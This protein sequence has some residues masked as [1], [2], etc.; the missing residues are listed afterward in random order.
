MSA[1]CSFLFIWIFFQTILCVSQTFLTRKTSTLPLTISFASCKI[2][3][4]PPPVL[5]LVLAN[6]FLY[7]FVF[8]S[9]EVSCKEV[10]HLLVAVIIQL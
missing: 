2:N 4:Y 8:E 9:F 1:Y 5:L 6:P 3:L 10:Y 7:C